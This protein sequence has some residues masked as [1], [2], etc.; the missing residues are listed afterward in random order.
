MTLTRAS[1]IG[2]RDANNRRIERKAPPAGRRPEARLR[3]GALL[4]SG[5][6]LCAA[7]ILAAPL[8]ASAKPPRLTLFI[9]VDA[10]SSDLLLRSRP[11]LKGGLARLVSE[12]AFYP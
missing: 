5:R 12:G 2:R 10:L 11:R 8:Q 1:T 4:R 3:S 9:V 6:V 7:L